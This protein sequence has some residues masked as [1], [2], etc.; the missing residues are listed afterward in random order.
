MS[1]MSLWVDIILRCCSVPKRRVR[2][3]RPVQ[4]ECLVCVEEPISLRRRQPSTWPGGGYLGHYSY[5]KHGRGHGGGHGGYGK[6][7]ILKSGHGLDHGH[8]HGYSHG[9][10]GGHGGYDGWW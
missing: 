3:G 7:I 5:G 8:G 10:G 4:A 2:K 9:L 6:V 1:L